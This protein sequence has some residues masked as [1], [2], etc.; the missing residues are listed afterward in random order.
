MRVVPAVRAL[1]NILRPPPQTAGGTHGPAAAMIR[2]GRGEPGE[3]SLET[4]PDLISGASQACGYCL[5][6]IVVTIGAAVVGG[7]LMG[8]R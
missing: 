5:L 4:T 7:I 8:R 6:E 1:D 3:T 2:P